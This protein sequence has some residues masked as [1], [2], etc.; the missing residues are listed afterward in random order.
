VIA[1]A[2]EVRRNAELCF[3]QAGARR[4]LRNEISDAAAS[5]TG[6]TLA[7]VPAND[8]SS[9]L[10]RVTNRRSE[11]RQQFRA[12]AHSH[13]AAISPLQTYAWA[14]VENQVLAAVKL[15]LLGRSAGQRMLHAL[16][17]WSPSL[18]SQALNF[19]NSDIGISTTSQALANGR[20]ETC[21]RDCFGRD[22]R[23][24]ALD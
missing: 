21:A 1:A 2:L 19:T 8:T 16:N 12:C 14:S 5:A 4:R 20:H 9:Q 23:R 13:I 7:E 24:A 6:V 11:S 17:P 22:L 3:Q 18:M 15:V 10:L